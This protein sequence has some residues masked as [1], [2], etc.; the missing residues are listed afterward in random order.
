MTALA[1]LFG[2]GIF[3]LDFKNYYITGKLSDAGEEEFYCELPQ[4]Y[5]VEQA[6]DW[7]AKVHLGLYG[8]P[9]SGKVAQLGL[10][11]K[12]LAPHG[13]FVRLPSSPMMF[14]IPFVNSDFGNPRCWF[15]C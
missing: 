15:L 2:L 9:P 14:K 8:W 5:E 11:D 12:L 10:E 6:G 3:V 1:V 13:E 4:G 7:V